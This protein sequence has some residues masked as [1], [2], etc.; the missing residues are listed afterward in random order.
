MLHCSNPVRALAHG[1]RT[2]SPRRNSALLRATA[3]NPIAAMCTIRV[4]NR[5]HPIRFAST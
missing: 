1:R 4:G 3:Q 5:D 2:I